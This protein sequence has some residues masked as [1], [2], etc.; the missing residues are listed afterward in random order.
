MEQREGVVRYSLQEAM[1]AR[2]LTH[3]ASHVAEQCGE[4]V[5]DVVGA[6]QEIQSSARRIA[7]SLQQIDR[8]TTLVADAGRT[9]QGVVEGVKFRAAPALAAPS[10]R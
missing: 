5:S 1:T 9:L 2:T 6:M 10:V 8:G 3:G 4:R 7:T